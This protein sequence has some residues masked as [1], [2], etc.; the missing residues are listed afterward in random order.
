[1]SE[2]KD[3]F[4][5]VTR[6]ADVY[7]YKGMSLASPQN[8][9]MSICLPRYEGGVAICIAL[10]LSFESTT[11]DLQRRSGMLLQLSQ[12]SKTQ[13]L[14]DHKEIL[15][16]LRD[17]TVHSWVYI[18]NMTADDQVDVDKDDVNGG[19][20][21][22]LT[23][24]QVEQCRWRMLA[25]PDD[26]NRN[27]LNKGPRELRSLAVLTAFAKQHAWLKKIASFDVLFQP[28]NVGLSWVHGLARQENSNVSSAKSL[29]VWKQQNAMCAFCDSF[30]HAP[31]G[32]GVGT[33]SLSHTKIPTCSMSSSI[34]NAKKLA[35]YSMPA[36]RFGALLDADGDGVMLCVECT[37]MYD[38]ARIVSG[39][40]S[41]R[42]TELAYAEG[43]KHWYTY[44]YDSAQ[45]RPIEWVD[46][47][48]L[49][50]VCSAAQLN[51]V[52]YIMACV[53]TNNQRQNPDTT[54]ILAYVTNIQESTTVLLE[55]P[56]GRQT[57]ALSAY[58][59]NFSWTTKT[60]NQ[61]SSY[62]ISNNA[63]T[64]QHNTIKKVLRD[65]ISSPLDNANNPLSVANIK[66]TFVTP[67][68]NAPAQ[69][70]AEIKTYITAMSA[71]CAMKHDLLF[72]HIFHLLYQMPPVAPGAP[73]T[74]WDTIVRDISTV[75]EPGL[76]FHVENGAMWHVTPVKRWGTLLPRFPALS[77]TT[78]LV[79]ELELPVG[80][81]V[82]RATMCVSIRIIQTYA[83]Q[84]NMVFLMHQNASTPHLYISRRNAHG[85][86]VV[87]LYYLVA[88]Y[89]VQTK[90]TTHIIVPQMLSN[91]DWA[92]HA[93]YRTPGISRTSLTSLYT[94]INYRTR[95]ETVSCY[96]LA[97]VSR[98]HSSMTLC[99]PQAR[100]AVNAMN[101]LMSRT[102]L[103]ALANMAQNNGLVK[104]HFRALAMTT[105][106][107]G[108]IV[109]T[110][111]KY[112]QLL[113]TE[114]PEPLSAAIQHVMLYT[115]WNTHVVQRFIAQQ[116]NGFVLFGACGMVQQNQIFTEFVYK[117]QQYVRA[118]AENPVQQ[119]RVQLANRGDLNMQTFF[120]QFKTIFM[121]A[122]DATYDTFSS[123]NEAFVRLVLIENRTHKNVFPTYSLRNCTQMLHY[124]MWALQQRDAEEY[125]LHVR[126]YLL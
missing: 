84:R 63:H 82:P 119:D 108:W 21:V 92:M 24:I 72:P 65:Y 31:D 89:H 103:T 52:Y 18:Y 123:T 75:V 28:Y 66:V 47:T 12:S 35:N 13:H 36:I 56:N 81:V 88:N 87:D 76:E 20:A 37:R 34:L 117:F 71:L 25:R 124:I 2:E 45:N 78:A 54:T 43:L 44:I 64:V 60:P 49:A 93:N 104:D 53:Y 30:T 55:L 57:T 14:L 23:N 113:Q 8:T 126:N 1:M 95:G 74:A 69:R 11:K 10:A 107:T 100:H 39:V 80:P 41:F 99:C 85:K 16:S 70:A 42:H 7:C 62:N 111:L 96:K 77:H 4:H 27:I 116:S 15:L 3:L 114:I 125:T 109:C 6:F 86:Q 46:K 51:S 17:S 26:F 22:P 19:Q 105:K 91:V 118:Y 33:M 102:K 110:E 94:A 97:R 90:T 38:K 40:L 58:V 59:K 32:Y 98:E 5:H 68:Q 61:L 83:L 73:S 115:F 79:V 112:R 101:T 9:D 122:S 121:D 29:E 50:D 48:F 67:N 106:L 120:T